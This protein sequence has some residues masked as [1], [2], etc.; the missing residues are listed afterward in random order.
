MLTVR[1]VADQRVCEWLLR[2][3]PFQL[4]PPCFV[5]RPVLPPEYRRIS[6]EEVNS[7]PIRVV[8]VTEAPSR[9]KGSKMLSNADYNDVL[10]ALKDPQLKKDSAI[11]VNMVAPQWTERRDNKPVYEK[12]EVAFAYTLRRYFESQSLP[13]IAYQ[14]GK[15][16]VTV[17]RKTPAE[18]VVHTRK[19]SK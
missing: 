18:S 16:E 14:S 6:I 2:Y 10:T 3:D 7:M 11:V 1:T 9:L 8:P 15:M 13:L 19:R 12:P 17:R 5:Y 4:A